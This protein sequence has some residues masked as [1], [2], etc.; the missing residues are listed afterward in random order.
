MSGKLSEDRNQ[1]SDYWLIKLNVWLKGEGVFE[2]DEEGLGTLEWPGLEG[3]EPNIIIYIHKTIMLKILI[4]IND[5]YLRIPSL[6]GGIN[7]GFKFH[8]RWK[9]I[10]DSMSLIIQAVDETFLFIFI[11]NK[12]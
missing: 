12:Y 11:S 4:F 3:F 7:A 8:F 5:M 9:M 1:S 6:V 10:S 2:R